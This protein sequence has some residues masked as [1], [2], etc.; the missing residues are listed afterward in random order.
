LNTTYW[1]NK[2]MDS[3]YGSSSGNSF[4]V[5]LSSTAPTDAGGNVTEPSGNG[6]A[7]VKISS[8]TAANAGAVKN[9]AAVVF[10][11]SNGTWFP[12]NALATHW[13]IFDGAGSSAKVLSSGTLEQSIGIWKNTTVTIAAGEIVLTLSDA[14]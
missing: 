13:V 5:G 2:V 9:A 7:R 3:V 6:Y 12:A 14:A 10:P 11:T 4:Y 8:F 1:R